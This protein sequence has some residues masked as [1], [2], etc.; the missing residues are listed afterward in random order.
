MA[1]LGIILF[2]VMFLGDSDSDLDFFVLVMSAL[3]FVFIISWLMTLIQ[4]WI[5]EARYAYGGI[6]SQKLED[7]GVK[8]VAR[9]VNTSTRMTWSFL[10]DWKLVFFGIIAVY[11]NIKFASTI[12]FSSTSSEDYGW[13][14]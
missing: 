10:G 6:I 4:K 11:L 5:F 2:L 3:F 8:K 1:V 14:F 13:F 12:Y 9:N 7:S